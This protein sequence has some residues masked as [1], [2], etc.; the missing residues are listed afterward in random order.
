MTYSLSFVE[1]DM[2]VCVICNNDV[3]CQFAFDVINTVNYMDVFVK[4]LFCVLI[5]NEVC[6]MIP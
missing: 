5:A 3:W 1:G 4:P 6:H 2:F